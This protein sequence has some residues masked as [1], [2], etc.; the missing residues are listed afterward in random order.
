MRRVAVTGLGVVSPLGCSPGE[1]FQ[2]VRA[3]RSGVR[4]LEGAFSHRLAAPLAATAPFS[5]DAHFDPPKL[6]MLDRVSQFALVA[7]RQAMA[8]AVAC[9]GD[10]DPSRAGVFAEIDRLHA[11]A[12]LDW[13]R[14][15][16]PVRP[17]W[18]P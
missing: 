7:A 16:A 10:A 1:A 13:R 6:R 3:G 14:N 12:F 5:G 2:N 11:F 8:D 17:I 18:N 4:R 9:P 15:L